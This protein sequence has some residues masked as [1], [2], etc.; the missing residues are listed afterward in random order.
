M[1]F[2]NKFHGSFLLPLL[3]PFIIACGPGK[4][5][6]TDDD[7]VLTIDTFSDF[8][9]EIYDCICIFSNNEIDF[10]NESYIYMNDY[11]QLSFL[12]INGVLTKFI[13]TESKKIDSL[14]TIEKFSSDDYEITVY[15]KHGEQ[16]GD[17]SWLY[18]GK[19]ELTN[20][21]GKLITKNFYGECGC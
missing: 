17:E 9:P 6:N 20:K 11:A 8:P 7:Q 15:T 5:K 18:T 12:K 10:K 14:N 1:I 13:Q 4:L 2:R 16:N 3:L 19:I 21:S